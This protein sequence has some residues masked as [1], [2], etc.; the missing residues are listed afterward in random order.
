MTTA[1]YALTI[2][3]SMARQRKRDTVDAEVLAQLGR[4]YAT[5]R[6]HCRA[7]CYDG[8][9]ATKDWED[10]LQETVLLVAADTNARGLSDERL[11]TLFVYR[12]D[13]VI[14]RACQDEKTKREIKYADHQF[15][16]KEKA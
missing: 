13:S 9:R 5:L 11:V 8:M 3:E 4:L 7:V 1:T 10:I 14:Y 15:R 6:D 2:T 16:E 12:M